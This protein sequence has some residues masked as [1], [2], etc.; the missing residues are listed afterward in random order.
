MSS[1]TAL[2]VSPPNHARVL[3]KTVHNRLR[4]FEWGD[5]TRWV[6]I[7]LLDKNVCGLKSRIKVDVSG[8]ARNTATNTG[9]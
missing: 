6:Y 1:P 5:F 9:G 8:K 7:W 3:V 4:I 2:W